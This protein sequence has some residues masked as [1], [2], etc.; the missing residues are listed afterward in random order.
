MPKPTLE[1]LRARVH[2]QTIAAGDDGYDT[3]RRVY[4]AMIDRRPR[5]IVRCTDAA[6]VMASVAFAAEHAIDLSVRGGSHSVPGFGTNDD[7]VVIDLAPMNGVRVDPHARTARAEGG[8]TWGGF[9]HAT[10]PFGL[11]TNGG[12]IGSTGIGGLTLGGGIGYLCRAFGLT[13][14]NLLS[15]DVV[16][17]DGRFLVASKTGQYG[18]LLGVARRRR[19]LRRGHVVRIPV[20]PRQGHRRG[21]LLFSR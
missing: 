18:S 10:Y 13:C 5:V 4:N 11:T 7:G 15:A 1:E 20:A 12:I 16:T 2:G 6:D 3:A 8:C 9:Y 19:E 14:D 17:A 21:T